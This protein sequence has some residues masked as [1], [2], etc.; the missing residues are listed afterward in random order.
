MIGGMRMKKMLMILV[1][2]SLLLVAGCE[3]GL[4]GAVTYNDTNDNDANET[5]G[6]VIGG[7][8]SEMESD[9]ESD[10]ES[11]ETE[12][13]ERENAY[14]DGKFV[15]TKTEGDL[16][17][18][19]PE[20]WDPDGDRVTLKFS[21]PFT[22]EG[23][24]QT[25]Y[26]D[27][28][29][30][31]V[32]VT[33]TD[34]KGAS[35]VETIIVKI[36]RANRAPHLKCPESIVVQEGETVF[37]DC[38]TND[39]EGE[40]VSLSFFGWMV[41]PSYETTYAD[42]GTHDVTVRAVDESGLSQERTIRIIVQDQNR[43]PLFPLDFANRLEGE[44]GDVFVI[45]TSGIYD[46]DGDVV[47]FTFSE[48]LDETGTWKSSKGDDGVY[49]VDVVASDGTVAVT[50]K[51]VI[52][53]GMVNTQPTLK[54]IPDMRV[55]EGETIVIPLEASDREGDDLSYRITGWFTTQEF[56]TGYDDAGSYSVTVSVSD[57]MF[58]D[59]QVVHIVVL[60]S[61]QATNLHSACVNISQLFYLLFQ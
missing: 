56:T 44:E 12:D 11:E 37:I 30:Y 53:I 20:T 7:E 45:D 2:L 40:R 26:G 41:G 21:A 46:P 61:E 8:D 38:E 28:G 54:R 14:E 25:A 51:V 6:F 19:A 4:L 23:R 42:A 33:A 18:L 32:V 1:V 29:E 36:L 24:W 10:V 39:E 58:E 55:Y 3:E 17:I 27:A 9:V 52:E 16:V 35:A 15:V 48:P 22:A 49:H 59:S 57:G 47:T 31:P 50:E 34:T 13:S 5:D 60:D 43:P